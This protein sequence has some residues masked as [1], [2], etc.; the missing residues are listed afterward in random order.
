MRAAILAGGLGTRL[1]PYTTILPKPL[2]PIGERPVLELIL[3]RLAAA[4]VTK[5]DMCVGHLGDL[6]RIY[7]TEGTDLPVELELAW[8]WEKEALGTAGALKV[9]PDLDGTFIAMNGDVLTNLDLR[10]LVDFHEQRGAALTVALHRQTVEIELGVVEHSEAQITGWREKPKLDYDVSMG[11]YVYDA[12]ALSYLPDGPCQF[13]DL[14]ERLIEAGETVVGFENDA[15]WFDIGT[16]GEYERALDRM[17]QEPGL[18]D[19]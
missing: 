5:V 11:I 9:I 10:A 7:F 13:P 6:I 3:R 15:E 18:F 1:R 12:R 19:G 17:E 2:L 4:G 8:H 14:V 16:F